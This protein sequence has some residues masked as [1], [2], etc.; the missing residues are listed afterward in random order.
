MISPDLGYLV[1]TESHLVSAFQCEVDATRSTAPYRPVERGP[2]LVLVM[3]A[4]S[5]R[6]SNA[7]ARINENRHTDRLRPPG[8]LPFV[9]FSFSAPDRYRNLCP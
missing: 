1:T 2:E 8:D 7:P 9:V 6:I 5:G 3:F 4:K